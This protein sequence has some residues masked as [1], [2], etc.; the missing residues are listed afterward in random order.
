[1]TLSHPQTD[2]TLNHTAFGLLNKHK[3]HSYFAKAFSFL[4][5]NLL[6]WAPN[7]KSHHQLTFWE[8]TSQ[9]G[10]Q[11]IAFRS[12]PRDPK[13]ILQI[14]KS[15]GFY[16]MAQVPPMTHQLITDEKGQEAAGWLYPIENEHTA[17][18]KRNFLQ[19]LFREQNYLHY[20]R[21]VYKA[22]ESVLPEG[23]FINL[24]IIS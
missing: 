7:R 5:K 10:H 22:R 14:Q 1:M 24:Q 9:A 8:V 21:K 11:I 15:C 13:L 18:P 23:I 17:F 19:E 12:A 4:F 6:W 20:Q 16:R 3:Q 2:L